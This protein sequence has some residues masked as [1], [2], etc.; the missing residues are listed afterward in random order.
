[1]SLA[2]NVRIIFV[3]VNDGHMALSDCLVIATAAVV[4]EET[5]TSGRCLGFFFL[6]LFFFDLFNSSGST[7]SASAASAAASHRHVFQLFH[8]RCQQF[9]SILSFQIRNEGADLG[10]IDLSSGSL[11]D[12]LDVIGTSGLASDHA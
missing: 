12:G 6:L 9:R 7:G 5:T 1:M 8:S 3:I 4:T 11:E 2:G 10:L